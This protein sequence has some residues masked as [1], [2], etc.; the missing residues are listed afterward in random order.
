MNPGPRGRRHRTV[1]ALVAGLTLCVAG[2]SAVIAASAASL[3]LTARPLDA[4]STQLAAAAPAVITCDNFS[5][6]GTLSG[7]SVTEVTT[8]G[9]FTWTVHTGSWS[10]SAGRASADGTAGAAAS[11]A[12]GA[13]DAAV[14]AAIVD[15]DTGGRQG[16]V[17]L[18]HD[19]GDDFLAAVLVGDD[20]DRVDLV[21]VDEG[22]PS[23]LATAATTIAASTRLEI[24]RVG[25]QITVQVDGVSLIDHTLTA[26]ELAALGSGTGAGLYASSSTIQI[27][28]FR[29]TTPNPV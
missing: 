17:L 15:A 22:A 7:R 12:A 21:L 24:V 3:D 28:D 25:D 1:T 13:A 11:V 14:V 6:D 27:D 9:A 18:A 10:T 5:S 20:P 2:G 26:G 19:G 23:V 29:V 4:W 16:G 8:C